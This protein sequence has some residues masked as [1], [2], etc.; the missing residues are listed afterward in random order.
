M[1]TVYAAL[2]NDRATLQRLGPALHQPPYDAPPR[3]PVLYIKT[4]NT[5]AQ[6]GTQVPVPR[7]PG[8]VQVNATLG[9]VI[10]QTATRVTPAHAWSH[11][12][13][14][15]I[16]S[17]LMLPNDSVYR[18]AVKQRCRDAFCP[19]TGVLPL[20]LLPDPDK[21][22]IT[23]AIDGIEVHRRELSQM[24]R[25]AAQLIA[26][27]TEFMSLNPGDILLLGPPEGAPLARP[28]QSVSIAIAELGILNHTLVEELP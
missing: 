18:P 24:V 10:G 11:L 13:G 25:S 19:M 3:A 12:R 28:G 21:A 7:D 5:L 14:Y 2:L 6:P 9:L 15:V 26:D 27:V 16:A 1:P 20:A 8:V 17:D 4:A 23:I 22:V